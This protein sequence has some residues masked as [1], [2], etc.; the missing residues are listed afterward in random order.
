MIAGL[1]AVDERARHVYPQLGWQL[2]QRRRPNRN[3]LTALNRYIFTIG[4]AVGLV[5]QTLAEFLL[6]GE[7]ILVFTFLY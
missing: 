4:N 5:H 1:Q 6:S 7:F 2:D 3:C